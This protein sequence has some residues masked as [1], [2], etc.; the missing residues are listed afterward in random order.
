MGGLQKRR[1][2]GFGRR[3]RKVGGLRSA[4]QRMSAPFEGLMKKPAEAPREPYECD[5]SWE[6]R[7]F[8]RPVS[9]QND[10]NR[11]ITYWFLID[12]LL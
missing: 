10:S 9:G 7:P 2:G 11:C 6:N 3:R 5:L 12:F 8:F 4:T 1:V